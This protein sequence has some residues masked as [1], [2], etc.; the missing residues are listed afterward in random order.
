VSGEETA[1]DY[2]VK[3]AVLKAGAERASTEG[4]AYGAP[5]GAVGATAYSIEIAGVDGSGVSSAGRGLA[6]VALFALG[7]GIA[8]LVRRR[9]A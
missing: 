7:A 8:T 1:Q 6:A 2:G 4:M 5:D 9:L 3:Y